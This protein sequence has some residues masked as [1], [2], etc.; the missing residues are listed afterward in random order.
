MDSHIHLESSIITPQNFAKAVVP[1]GTT[2]VVT[3]PHEITNVMGYDGFDYMLE[4]TENLPIDVYFTVPSCV[5][6]TQFD[7]NG[8]KITVNEVQNTS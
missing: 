6:A 7:E 8:A 4:A 2:A 5:P 3:D 1:H